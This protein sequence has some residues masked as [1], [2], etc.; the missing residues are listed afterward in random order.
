[1][2]QLKDFDITDSRKHLTIEGKIVMMLTCESY[3]MIKTALSGVFLKSLDLIG[4]LDYYKHF[5]NCEDIISKLSIAVNNGV[6][7]EDF[8][9]NEILDKNMWD[10]IK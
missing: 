10:Y 7:L 6:S 8:M 5:N 4:L 9:N 1:M 2:N 3:R